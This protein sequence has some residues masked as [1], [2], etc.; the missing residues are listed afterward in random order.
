MEYLTA[1]DIDAV[2]SIS[3]VPTILRVV[4]ETTG[5]GF[6][7]IARVTGDSWTTCAVLDRVGFGLQPGDVL[8]VATTLCDQVRAD[9]ALIVI[10]QASEDPVY[11]THPTPKQYGFESYISVPVYRS[12]GEFFGTLCGLD[13]RPAQL[14]NPRILD[15]LK[16]FAELISR[17]L[18][19]ES[20]MSASETAL[21]NERESSELRE[22]FIAVLGHDLRTP[23]SSILTGAELL[24]RLP[25]EPK[26]L[27][28]VERIKRSGRR[29]SSLVDDVVDFTR[30]RMGGGIALNASDTSELGQHLRHVV[31]ELTD[32]H[33][34]RAVVS[35]IA[36]DDT[37][38]CDPKRIAQMLSNLL[39]NALT[40]GAQDQPVQVV[41][42]SEDGGIFLSVTNAGMPIGPEK[43]PQLFQ[44]FRRGTNT[45]TADGLGLGLYIASEI[46]R[47][48]GGTLSVTSTADATTFSFTLPKPARE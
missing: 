19:D 42:R 45:S 35:D 17:Q 2:Q 33:A 32:V 44:P 29:M 47:S 38:F 7:C 27:S 13:R 21:L 6:V 20:R 41:A 34:G 31:A 37:V 10:D 43:M 5:L 26:A 28:I 4:A 3:A 39:V 12:N 9:D 16:L 11:R 1:A 48:H 22:Q 14:S 40:H 24:Q 25:L 23:L 36:L 18:E 8:D 46:A 30:G 15:T